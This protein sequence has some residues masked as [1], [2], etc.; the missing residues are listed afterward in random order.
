M[1]GLF[2]GGTQG[3]GAPAA[4]ALQ[5][6]S[7]AYGMTLPIVWGCNRVPVNLIWYGDFSSSGGGSGGKGGG[8]KGGSQTSYAAAVAM[9][10]CEGPILGIG[11]IW[12]D[13]SHYMPVVT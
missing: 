9:G 6:Q 2:G 5:V 7:S 3:G 11:D 1:G 10:I 12:V 4:G 13:Q 8:G